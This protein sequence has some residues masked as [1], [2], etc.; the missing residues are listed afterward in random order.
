MIQTHLLKL[1]PPYQIIA[2]RGE[3]GVQMQLHKSLKLMNFLSIN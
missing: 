3:V 1:D 2:C